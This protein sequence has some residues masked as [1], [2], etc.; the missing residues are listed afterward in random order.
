MN[1]PNRPEQEA[2]GFHQNPS[3]LSAGT[4]SAHDLNPIVL[5]EV[6]E[7]E[8]S[9]VG[10]GYPDGSNGGEH[11]EKKE[12][13]RERAAAVLGQMTEIATRDA[14]ESGNETRGGGERCVYVSTKCL[15]KVRDVVVKFGTFVGPG[16]MVSSRP[17]SFT[18]RILNFSKIAVAYIDPGNYSTDIAAG[19]TYRFKLLF[20][21]MMS[22]VFAVFLQSLCIKLGSVS[23]LNLAEA[24][25]KFLPRW[26]NI[27]LYIMAE[28]A[29]GCYNT[30]PF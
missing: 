6:R 17:C 22:N 29:V 3:S 4:A 25:R 13:V 9:N 1:Y 7:N 21:V 30:T 26:L 27:S 15:L 12:A 2:P 23:G 28:A 14:N 19:A 24:C 18:Q 10:F 16:F 11:G 5:G 20:I 8:I